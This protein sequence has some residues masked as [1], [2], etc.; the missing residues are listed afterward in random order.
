MRPAPALDPLA[1]W[2]W[3]PLRAQSRV[4]QSQRRGTP[5]VVIKGTKIH[6]TA[7]ASIIIYQ[8]L[9]K[10][11]CELVM[12]AE[13]KL[14]TV[15]GCKEWEVINGISAARPIKRVRLIAFPVS[16]TSQSEVIYAILP[17]K[18]IIYLHVRQF[19]AGKSSCTISRNL[20]VCRTSGNC[21]PSTYV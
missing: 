10:T 20:N 12:R 17:Y 9:R 2:R 7:N 19:F 6:D 14:T 16:P 21:G 11:V 4:L 8:L 18:Y 3:R 5:R 1:L 15:H 13:Q